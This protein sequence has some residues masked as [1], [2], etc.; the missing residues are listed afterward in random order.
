MVQDMCRLAH[1]LMQMHS[2]M[3]FGAGGSGSACLC[4]GCLPEGVTV[5]PPRSVSSLPAHAP[6]FIAR[7]CVTVL[8]QR[9]V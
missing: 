2:H 6:Q 9:K 8:Q 7:I 5:I 3:D 1:W 4:P